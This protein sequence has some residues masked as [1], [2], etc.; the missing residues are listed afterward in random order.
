MPCDAAVSEAEESCRAV[1]RPR[2]RPPI[3]LQY[4]AN[5]LCGFTVVERFV[6]NDTLPVIGAETG[7]QA[8]CMIGFL[9]GGMAP[10]RGS[11]VAAAVA[12]ALFCQN[13][14]AGDALGPAT[15][16]P[17]CASSKQ[18]GSRARNFRWLPYRSLYEGQ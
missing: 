7:G 18:N 15:A 14:E 12:V 10:E 4:R 11:P 16:A 9:G 6:Q 1:A 2:R 13:A 3:D 8:I 17:S 5:A